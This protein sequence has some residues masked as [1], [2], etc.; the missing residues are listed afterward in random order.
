[1]PKPRCAATIQPQPPAEPLMHLRQVAA[2]NAAP[3][4]RPTPKAALAPE[5]LADL[6]NYLEWMAGDGSG[7][8]RE[9]SEREEDEAPPRRVYRPA[10]LMQRRQHL[11]RAAALLA[12]AR[13]EPVASVKSLADLVAAADPEDPASKGAATTILTRYR[14]SLPKGSPTVQQMAIT[15][16]M[17]ACQHLPHDHDAK[18]RMK[19]LVGQITSAKPRG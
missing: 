13:G 1:M 5:F 19:R 4:K 6:A 16:L 14:A 9:F 8:E 17:M 15:L 18:K 7:A 11:C 2:L 12:E 3:G 10:T